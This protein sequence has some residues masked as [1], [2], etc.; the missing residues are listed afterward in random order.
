MNDE[1]K[2]W[3]AGVEKQIADA[4]ASTDANAYEELIEL[5]QEAIDTCLEP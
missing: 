4:K 5:L 1:Q 3:L 2:Q